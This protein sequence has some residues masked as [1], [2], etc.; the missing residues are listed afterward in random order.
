MTKV[1]ICGITNVEDARVA[2]EAG[3]DAIGFVFAES[4][5]R[6]T[7]AK[8][9]E[10][11][12]RIDRKTCVATGVFVDADVGLIAQVVNDVGLGCV[13]LSGSESV[14]TVKKVKSFGLSVVKSFRISTEKD[15]RVLD[16]FQPDAYL[17]D[18]YVAG[19]AGGTGR[20]FDWNLAAAARHVGPI[21]LAG[22][23][24]VDNVQRALR[25]VEPYGV[26]AS[27][28]LERC[29]GVKDPELVREFIRLVKGGGP[30]ANEG[31]RLWPR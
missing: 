24:G 17:L 13:Q 22:G 11:W 16:A 2:V 29:P 5:R 21:I 31:S 15:I 19:L 27:S 3:A 25:A 10:I 6:I 14:E 18:T 23:L 4:P 9:K 12:S 26:D 30:S 8:A 1:K 20:T 7:V 28:R